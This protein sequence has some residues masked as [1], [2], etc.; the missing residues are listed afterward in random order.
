MVWSC[1]MTRQDDLDPAGYA[2]LEHKHRLSRVAGWAQ[3]G[4]RPRAIR[5]TARP[6]VA[7]WTPCP[8]LPLPSP[9]LECSPRASSSW[10]TRLARSM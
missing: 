3:T 5:P 2:R 9:A 7:R 8:P 4:T 1:A 10:H 6:E